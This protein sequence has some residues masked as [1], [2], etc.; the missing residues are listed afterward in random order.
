MRDYICQ[1]CGEVP[2]AKEHDGEV[3]LA[4]RCDTILK[5]AAA[6]S[7]YLPERWE[8]KVDDS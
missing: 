4:C 7:P 5:V 8:P 1:T 6:G 3:V 2:E